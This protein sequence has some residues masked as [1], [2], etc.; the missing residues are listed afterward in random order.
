MI[1]LPLLQSLR[2]VFASLSLIGGFPGHRIVR[3]AYRIALGL[4]AA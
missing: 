3:G 1:L 4:L 2:L